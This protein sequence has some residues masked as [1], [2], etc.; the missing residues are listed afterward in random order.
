MQIPWQCGYWQQVN[1][2]R[3][4]SFLD[5]PSNAVPS[6]A[7]LETGQD[8]GYVLL[9]CCIV[10]VDLSVFYPVSRSSPSDCFETEILFAEERT[11]LSL[12]TVVPGGRGAGMALA[13][14]LGR[15]ESGSLKR[16]IVGNRF[17]LM[18]CS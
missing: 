13:D 8:Y 9:L 16:L 2:V 11:P 17:P 14:A 3:N 10:C 15:T 1:L 4:A 6:F 12:K 18:L 5:V 7:L